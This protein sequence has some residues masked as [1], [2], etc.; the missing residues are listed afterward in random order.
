MSIELHKE[1]I[2]YLPKMN[3]EEIASFILNMNKNKIIDILKN[4]NKN[5]PL[6]YDGDLKKLKTIIESFSFLNGY[7]KKGNNN[8]FKQLLLSTGGNINFYY[9]GTILIQGNPKLK[10]KIEKHLRIAL[11]SYN[12]NC[13]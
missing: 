12:N 1:L 2:Q 7:W 13:E 9:N 11:N 5:I 6:K 8:L 4:N 3:L 10:P